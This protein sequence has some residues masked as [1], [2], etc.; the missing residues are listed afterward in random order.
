MSDDNAKAEALRI[1]YD[2]K[3]KLGWSF[4]PE[5]IGS[6][7]AKILRSLNEGLTNDR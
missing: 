7:A 5:D 2:R 4:T 1:A 3:V 6:Y